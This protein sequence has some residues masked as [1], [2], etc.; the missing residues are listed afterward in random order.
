MLQQL[1]QVLISNIGNKLTRELAIG[2]MA[3]I[4]SDIAK[5]VEQQKTAKGAEGAN[6]AGKSGS[7]SEAPASAGQLEKPKAVAKKATAARA[8][9]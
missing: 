2:M 6:S 8:K 7:P 4:K 1:E 3:A 9:R 5:L